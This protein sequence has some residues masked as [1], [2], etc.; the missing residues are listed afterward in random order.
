VRDTGAGIPAT[1]LDRIFDPARLVFHFKDGS[2]YQETTVFS[3]RE[4]FRLLSDHLVQRGPSFKQ[5]MET[6]IDV[7]TGDVS[8]RY[9]DDA[10]KRR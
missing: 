9:T 10:K 1:I 7:S 2:I 3:Q 6:S 8:V 5:Q 4:R